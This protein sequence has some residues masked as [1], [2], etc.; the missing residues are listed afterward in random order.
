MR[1]Q[2]N[3]AAVEQVENIMKRMGYKTH[4]HALQVMLSTITNNLRRVDEKASNTKA[5]I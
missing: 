2:L 5:K 3:Y 4:Q 1:I